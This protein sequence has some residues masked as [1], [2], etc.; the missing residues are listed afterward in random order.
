MSY[1]LCG[2]LFVL[3]LIYSE[4]AAAEP[5]KWK[6]QASSNHITPANNEAVQAAATWDYLLLVQQWPGGVCLTEKEHKCEVPSS[7]DH[8]TVHGMW[9]NCNDGSNPTGCNEKDHFQLKE[10]HPIIKEMN[11]YWSNLYADNGASSFWA[12]EWDKHGTCAMVLPELRSELLYF[13]KTLQVQQELDLMKALQAGGITPSSNIT[14]A[15]DKI[16]DAV[17]RAH[18]VTPLLH[19]ELN[20][21]DTDKTLSS[22]DEK[23]VV[24]KQEILAEIA[25]CV[26]KSFH[27]FEC[28]PNMSA[29]G[30]GR[31]CGPEVVYYPNH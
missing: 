24:I 22:N 27:A 1:S 10:I 25:L 5:M 18:G 11:L 23:E 9:P 14:Y 4:L 8:L 30:I 29:K 2:L 7:V 12:H 13:N 16:I 31:P 26:D 19:C 20:K 28:P 3:C 15:R 6:A 17:K 21:I